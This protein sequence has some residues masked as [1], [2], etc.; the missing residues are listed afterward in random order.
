M[1]VQF[2][3][4]AGAGAVGTAAQFAILIALVELAGEN[5]VIASTVGAVAGAAINYA[6]NHRLTFSSR[7]PH[8]RALPR[9]AA[10]ALVGMALNALVVAGMLAADQGDYVL[11][12]VVATGVVLVF[13]YASNRT[14]TF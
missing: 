10:V 7:A 4:Y 13:T 1:L 9:F 3:R 12:Q 2:L 11:A 14:W 6:I 8:A 5:A